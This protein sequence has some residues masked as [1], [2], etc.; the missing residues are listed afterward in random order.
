MRVLVVGAGAVGGYFGGRLLQAGC[1]V[2]FLVRPRRAA[3]LAANGLVIRDSGL[4]FPLPGVRAIVADQ[5]ETPFDL[6]LLSCKAYDLGSAMTDLA[7][8]V[9]P[10]TTILPILNGLR[11]IEQLCGRFGAAR[12]IGGLCAIFVTLDRQGHVVL[13]GRTP[14]LTFGELN[15]GGSARVDAIANVL[16]TA[17]FDMRASDTIML[18]MWEKWILLATLSGM[19][20]L[21]RGTVGDIVAAG[22]AE[23]MEHLLEECRGIAMAQGQTPRPGALARARTTLTQAGSAFAASMLRDLENGAATEVEHVLGDL[24]NRQSNNAG[25]TLSLLRIAYVHLRTYETKRM[26]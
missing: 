11:H 20:C 15:G 8:A 21:M 25:S 10:D 2:T 9:G 7:P 26:R 12:V 4:E 14:S 1:D 3:Q 18:D 17:T 19:T 23:L 16:G 22:G 6:V 5:L 24:I 13:L